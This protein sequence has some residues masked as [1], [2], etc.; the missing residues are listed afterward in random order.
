MKNQTAVKARDE[1]DSPPVLALGYGAPKRNGS[2]APTGDQSNRL[3]PLI[4]AAENSTMKNRKSIAFTRQAFFV[5]PHLALL[6]EAD[7]SAS[8]PSF[9]YC[10]FDI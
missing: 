6:T 2:E 7:R 3:T 9:P 10:A 4:T 1:P 5:C 8:R